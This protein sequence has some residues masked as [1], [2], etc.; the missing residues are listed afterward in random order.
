MISRY[1]NNMIRFVL[2]NPLYTAHAS[3]PIS[4]AAYYWMTGMTFSGVICTLILNS[5]V[6][7][8]CFFASRFESFNPRHWVSE[9]G[10]ISVEFS[11][12]QRREAEVW[13]RQ[14]CS[15]R[16]RISYDSVVFSRRDDAALF[17]LLFQ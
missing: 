14:N 8:Y 5:I 15:G 2:E 4:F 9:K 7:M 16:W 6:S 3:V 13:C 12:S 1:V 10:G 17:T 11:H